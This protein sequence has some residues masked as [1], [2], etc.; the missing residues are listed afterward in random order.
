MLI[1]AS[2]FTLTAVDAIQFGD[3]EQLTITVIFAKSTFLA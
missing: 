3:L 1:S 2:A